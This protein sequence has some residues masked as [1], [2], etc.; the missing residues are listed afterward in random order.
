MSKIDRRG[1]LSSAAGVGS[2][3]ALSGCKPAPVP[4]P[5]P[6]DGVNRAL[7]DVQ[8]T[9]EF[10][11][12]ERTLALVP[13]G[14]PTAN[15]ARLVLII[16]GLCAYII[17]K[18]KASVDLVLMD[19]RKSAGMKE[20]VARLSME[21]PFV[22]TATAGPEKPTAYTLPKV[23]SW[24]LRGTIT[25]FDVP[26]TTLPALTVDEESKENP[27]SSIHWHLDLKAAAGAG[28]N[29]RKDSSNSTANGAIAAII[30]LRHGRLESGPPS[31]EK[32]VGALW[33]IREIGED[34][35]PISAPKF[36]QLLSDT[37]VYYL[38]LPGGKNEV[39]VNRSALPGYAPAAT[40]LTPFTITAA[41]PPGDMYGS[42][43]HDIV[44]DPTGAEGAEI[45]PPGH[46][47]NVL[48]HNAV[49]YQLFDP[50]PATQPLPL[51]A[52]RWKERGVESGY[53][54][55][56]LGVNEGDPNCNGAWI[57]RAES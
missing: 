31:R 28:V 54:S 51:M 12:A 23:K 11:T 57:I 7:P 8:T 6:S 18:D 42:I 56:Y 10:E 40:D 48:Y 44:K 30:R 46:N 19:H 37:A 53:R 50:P 32:N 38:E 25:T 21:T 49:F 43:T 29:L 3:L 47:P 33:D 1:F 4:D 20:H 9:A 36:R 24:D 34:G 16:R 41:N 5:Q 15:H 27:W 13:M 39:V 35:Q 26:D 55:R 22:P 45:H 17:A 14:S 52:S 2:A